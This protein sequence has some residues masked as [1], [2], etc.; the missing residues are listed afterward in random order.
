MCNTNHGDQGTSIYIMGIEN[1]LSTPKQYQKIKR[2]NIKWKVTIFWRKK[3]TIF[4]QKIT[5][6]T[7]TS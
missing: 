4:H 3:N 6:K 5:R 7:E 2:I 1:I